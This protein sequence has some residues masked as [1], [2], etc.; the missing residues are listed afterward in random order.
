M[1][2][3]LRVYTPKPLLAF[4]GSSALYAESDIGAIIAQGRVLT[5]ISAKTSL[6]LQ[7]RSS[8]HSQ[9]GI[10]RAAG[11]RLPPHCPLPRLYQTKS[12]R[13]HPTSQTGRQSQ[14]HSKRYIGSEESTDGS[15]ALK[16]VRGHLNGRTSRSRDR[17]N[18]SAGGNRGTC[19]KLLPQGEL[20]NIAGRGFESFS[21]S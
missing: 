4:S 20:C 6:P 1:S 13:Y 11:G 3:F 8:T 18:L 5:N 16:H 14:D 19:L 9:D 10:Y 2:S 21:T 7:R 12:S 15:R 17:E